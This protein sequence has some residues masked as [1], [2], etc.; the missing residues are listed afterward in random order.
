[1]PEL[2]ERLHYKPQTIYNK[3]S[4]G[5]LQLG[6]HYFKPAG[7]LFFSWS[8]MEE[9]VRTDRTETETVEPFI[10]ERHARTHK[11]R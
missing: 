1:M 10:A 7:R 2:C 6:V 3:M 11:T 4:T 8:A 5:E 9:W